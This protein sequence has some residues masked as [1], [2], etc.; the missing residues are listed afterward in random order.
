MMKNVTGLDLVKTVLRGL[1]HAWTA[2]RSD[3]QVAAAPAGRSHF[4]AGGSVGRGC[5][6]GARLGIVPRRFEITGAAHLPAG[7]EGAHARHARAARTLGRVRWAYRAERLIAHLAPFGTVSRIEAQES[8]ALWRDIAGVAPF[9]RAQ[10]PIVWK[11]SLPAREARRPP[12]RGSRPH[13]AHAI[14]MI[15][16]AGSSGWPCCRATTRA[17]A[18]SAMPRASLAGTPR[19][20]GA[21]ADIRR[22]IDVFPPL[23]APLMNIT[24]GLKVSFDPDGIFN[25][26]R[27]YA[28][29]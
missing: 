20:C 23:G 17:R 3:V 11:V 10:A 25:P 4:G 16:A 27:M 22:S 1:R 19:S 28:G 29:V 18:W 6:P 13:S 21:P 5:D 26:G 7:I 9:A 2:D 24:T 15:G 14:S 8:R 12:W